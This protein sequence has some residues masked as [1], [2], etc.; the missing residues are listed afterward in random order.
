MSVQ[1]AIRGTEEREWETRDVKKN[2]KPNIET[3]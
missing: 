2:V 1:C 3:T